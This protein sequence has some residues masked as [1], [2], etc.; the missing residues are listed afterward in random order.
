MIQLL[1]ESFATRYSTWYL[2]PYYSTV[3]VLLVVVVPVRV[4]GS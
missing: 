1:R 2:V 4:S 3:V